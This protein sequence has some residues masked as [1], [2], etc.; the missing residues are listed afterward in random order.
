MNPLLRSIAVG[1]LLVAA[2]VFA[3]SAFEGRVTFA[4]TSSTGKPSTTNYAAKGAMMLSETVLTGSDSATAGD[5]SPSVHKKK[6][7]PSE[8]E[9]SEEAPSPSGSPLSFLH[10]K[11][12]KKPA[13]EG[14][15][16]KKLSGTTITDFNK[17]EMITLM[18][19]QKMYMVMSLRQAMKTGMEQAD[20]TAS[21]TAI[22]RTGKTEKILGYTAEQIISR[23]TEKGTATEIWVTSELGSF[24]GMGMGMAGGGGGGPFAEKK[25]PASAKWAEALSGLGGFTLRIVNTNKDGKETFRMEATKIEPGSLPDSLFVPPADYKKFEMPDL[26]SLNPFK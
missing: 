21:K 5:K 9:A 22:E 11:K 20:K 26:G 18:P 14:S 15:E 17:M 6:P 23:D 19:D 4:M 10:S 8:A 12:P 24:M 1:A 3:A 2:P 25:G 16:D 13:S 7:N